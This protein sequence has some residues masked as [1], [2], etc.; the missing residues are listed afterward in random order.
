MLIN[1]CQENTRAQQKKCNA[2]RETRGVPYK[3][4]D[5]VRLKLNAVQKNALGGKKISPRNSDAY[6]VTEVNRQWTYVLRKESYR[7][8]QRCPN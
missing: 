1:I 3:V 6:G 4:G 2:N 8:V 7:D 5:L